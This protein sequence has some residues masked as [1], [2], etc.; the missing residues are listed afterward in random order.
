MKLPQQEEQE[1]LITELTQCSSSVS[2]LQ[3]LASPDEEDILDGKI[4]TFSEFYT[5]F[6]SWVGISKLPESG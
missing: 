2:D 5:G 4:T 3:L 1:Y 6:N